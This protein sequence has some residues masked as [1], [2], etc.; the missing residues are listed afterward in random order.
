MADIEPIGSHRRDGE[1]YTS[2]IVDRLRAEIVGGVLEPEQK[3]RVRTLAARFG[4]GLSP[5]REALN[6]LSAEGLVNQI[7]RRGFSVAPVSEDDLEEM[8]RT[9]AWLNE[10]ALRES[11]E[12]G[13]A[14]WEEAVLVAH[15][16]LARQPR[17]A[18]GGAALNQEWD[19]AHR[20]FH[21]SLISACRSHWLISYCDQMFDVALRYRNFARTAPSVDPRRGDAEHRQIM[22]ATLARDSESAVASLLAHF[23]TVRDVCV[24]ELRRRKAGPTMGE[25]RALPRRRRAAK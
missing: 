1:T 13:D 16:R 18:T 22:E 6:R 24:H 17:T 2:A 12:H 9:R 20:A 25:V 4:V 23:Q 7:D 11:I 14:A 15:H 3:L 5:I 19:A 8:I 21:R 10:R